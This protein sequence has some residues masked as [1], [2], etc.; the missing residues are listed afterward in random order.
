M[1][2]L[3]TGTK[4]SE[5]AVLTASRDV[6]AAKMTLPPGAASDDDVSNEHSQSEQWLFVLSGSGEAV[7]GRKRSA[8]RRVRLARGSLLLIE[9]HELHQ[10][11]NT[12]RKTMSAITFYAPPAYRPNGEPRSRP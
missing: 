12:G 9:K 4:R 3:R 2:H 10:I 7:V 5:F 8:V 6:Q 11:R 1:K